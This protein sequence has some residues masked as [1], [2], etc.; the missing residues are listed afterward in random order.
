MAS[1]AAAGAPPRGA[2]KEA[3]A[4][5]DGSLQSISSNPQSSSS[6]IAIP[7]R[8]VSPSPDDDKSG[9]RESDTFEHVMGSLDRSEEGVAGLTERISGIGFEMDMDATRFSI[10]DYTMGLGPDGV[11]SPARA[12][13]GMG[14]LM[15]MDDRDSFVAPRSSLS[16][17]EGGDRESFAPARS[18][19]DAVSGPRTS[20]HNP[21]AESERPS[22]GDAAAVKEAP[23]SP[24]T[25][26]MSKKSAGA[27]QTST[28]ENPVAFDDEKGLTSIS[29]DWVNAAQE[30]ADKLE[31]AKFGGAA[32]VLTTPKQIKREQS[33]CDIAE[34]RQIWSNCCGSSRRNS[35]ASVA[36]AAQ[37]Q[38]FQSDKK[39]D[40][41][42]RGMTSDLMMGRRT[43]QKISARDSPSVT[44]QRKHPIMNVKFGDDE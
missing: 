19:L 9:D 12:S 21:F 26:T 41:T 6:A 42:T 36:G 2:D 43:S 3:Y 17:F 37:Q 7:R 13:E 35:S 24:I 14:S 40:N 39:R 23:V 10:G 30:P 8:G 25:I 44:T 5:S 27:E 20:L 15:S 16:A 29:N 38:E 33:K 22:V 31:M 4:P 11:P 18:S 28:P 1:L 32:A 34:V